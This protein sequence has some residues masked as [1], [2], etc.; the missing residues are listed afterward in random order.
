MVFNCQSS[1]VKS[2]LNNL[3]KGTSPCFHVS[4]NK[5]E[6]EN[7]CSDI[8][9][10]KSSENSIISIAII[11]FDGERYRVEVQDFHPIIEEELI[12][13]FYKNKWLKLYL[14][15]IKEISFGIVDTY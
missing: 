12:Q 4:M 14:S 15:D 7:I 1:I 2:C 3:K 8:E 10:I 5:R 11:F 6:F 13:I 9:M